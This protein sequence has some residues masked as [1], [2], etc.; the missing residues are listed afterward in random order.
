MLISRHRARNKMASSRNHSQLLT[1]E[2]KLIKDNYSLQKFL[3][4][5]QVEEEAKATEVKIDRE[6]ARN[7]NINKV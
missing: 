6:V 3:E 1:G 2:K 5:A 7:A 4:E